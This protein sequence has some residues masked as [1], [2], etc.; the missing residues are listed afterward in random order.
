MPP[1]NDPTEPDFEEPY[2]ERVGT[3]GHVGTPA[4]PDISEMLRREQ[5]IVKPFNRWTF[6]RQDGIDAHFA[7]ERL[8]SVTRW[9][10][11]FWKWVGRGIGGVAIGIFIAGPPPWM[12]DVWHRLEAAWKAFRQ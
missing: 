10:K 8:R 3:D 1:P 4:D 12:I 7:L 9:W 5:A 11:A 6:T 2:S